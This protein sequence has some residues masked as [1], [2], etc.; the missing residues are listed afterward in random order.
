MTL[1]AKDT[2]TDTT[3]LD[4]TFDVTISSNNPPS[5]NN[6]FSNPAS[7]IAHNAFT[8]T[9]PTDTFTEPN[10]EPITITHIESVAWLTCYDANRSCEG[11]PSNTELGNHNVIL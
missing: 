8:F 10:S 11:T 5:I 4:E 1:T 9:Y 7:F 2:W 3:T 6:A